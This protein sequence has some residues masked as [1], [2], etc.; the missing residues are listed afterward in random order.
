M[1]AASAMDEPITPPSPPPLPYARRP[2]PSAAGWMV[3]LSLAMA[4][5]LAAGAGVWYLRQQTRSLS[6]DW[7]AVQNNSGPSVRRLQVPPRP[8][9]RIPSSASSSDRT[10]QARCAANLTRIAAA[11]Q[12][13]ANRHDWRYPDRLEDLVQAG[14]LSPDA[15]SCPADA[16]GDGSPSYVYTARGLTFP[17]DPDTILLHER[18]ASH[19][20]GEAPAVEGGMHVLLASGRAKFMPAHEAEPL[21]AAAS[22]P[23]PLTLP[24]TRPD[25]DATAR[26]VSPDA[27]RV[28]SQ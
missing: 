8:D 25:S 13:Y 14:L 26:S 23:G 19:H 10:H 4:I 20:P 3:V 17:L 21:L 15:L 7:S 24:A 28:D 1:I 27:Q 2:R 9:G 5:G 18:S 12:A 16:G 22:R 11:L 6:A